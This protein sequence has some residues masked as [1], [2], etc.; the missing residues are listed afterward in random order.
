MGEIQYKG[1]TFHCII[2]VWEEPL[3]SKSIEKL[4]FDLKLFSCNEDGGKIWNCKSIELI[5]AQAES[6]SK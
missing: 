4:V 6:I 1:L 5:S 2:Y 3:Q